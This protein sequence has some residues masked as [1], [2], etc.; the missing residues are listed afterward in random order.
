MLCNPMAIARQAPLSV[1]FSR[2]EYW[3]V[4]KEMATHSSMLAWK[5][6]WTEEPGRLQSMGSQR[7]EHNWVM[8]SIPAEKVLPWK[9]Y[10][11]TKTSALPKNVSGSINISMQQSTVVTNLNLKWLSNN[12]YFPFD[13]L[14]G[15]WFVIY[16][17]REITIMMWNSI[18]AVV[19]Y[20]SSFYH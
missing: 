17:L 19:F 6:P 5:I 15:L 18:F 1:E 9:K 12:P 14:D 3:S 2:Q 10:I 11:Y 13:K 20:V 8:G 16:M 7:V 4:E